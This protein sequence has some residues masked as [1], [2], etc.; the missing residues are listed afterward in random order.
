MPGGVGN[1]REGFAYAS[2]GSAV[3]HRNHSTQELRDTL[4]CPQCDYSL[5]GLDG[6]VVVCPECGTRCDITSMMTR[7]WTEPWY[8]APGFTPLLLPLTWLFIAS[9]GEVILLVVDSFHNRPPV[10][11]GAGS[12]VMIGVWIAMLRWVRNVAGEGKGWKLALLAHALFAGY[13]VGIIGVAWLWIGAWYT[14]NRVMTGMVLAM[15][16]LPMALLWLMRRGEKYIASQCIKAWLN[17]PGEG[18]SRAAERAFAV[19]R[20]EL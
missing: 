10:L 16:L 18:D 4:T 1:R 20:G 17:R 13:I 2:Y 15:S 11:A 19:E 7:R 14:G 12:V 9:I 3:P 8:R 5:R 6:A